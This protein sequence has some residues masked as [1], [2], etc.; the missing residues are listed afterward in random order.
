MYLP[1]KFLVWFYLL[2]GLSNTL[3]AIEYFVIFGNNLFI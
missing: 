1:I 2:F 3:L